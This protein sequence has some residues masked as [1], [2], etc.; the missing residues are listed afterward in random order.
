MSS[1]GFFRLFAL[2]LLIIVTNNPTAIYGKGA[3]KVSAPLYYVKGVMEFAKADTA[4]NAQEIAKAA[5][6]KKAFQI[7]VRRLAFAESSSMNVSEELL[8]S[9]VLAYAVENERMS[10]KNYQATFSFQFDPEGM[11]NFLKTEGV[12]FTENRAARILLIPVLRKSEDIKIWEG[13]VWADFWKENTVF[14]PLQP[15]NLPKRDLF[16]KNNWPQESYPE[17]RSAQ[18]EAFLNHYK[19]SGIVVAEL[20]LTTEGAQLN[21]RYYSKSGYLADSAIAELEGTDIQELFRLTQMQTQSFLDRVGKRNRSSIRKTTQVLDIVIPAE[22]VND[23]KAKISHLLEIENIQKVAEYEL[24]NQQAVA[25]LFFEGTLEDLQEKLQKSGMEL[26]RRGECVILRK[27]T[28][29]PE[30]ETTESQ[31]M[32][33]SDISDQDSQ[34]AE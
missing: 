21:L 3:T 34:S 26:R 30:E 12:D 15:Y 19:T 27:F 14:S 2:I 8:E 11:R 5:A 16:D 4:V 1:V 24:S 31:E 17:I 6:M 20:N 22:D 18:V 32:M 10:G 13:N 29:E 9:L 23:L 28:P 7:L 33:N 25:R